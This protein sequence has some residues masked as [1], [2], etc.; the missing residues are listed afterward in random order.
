MIILQFLQ[1]YTKSTPLCNFSFLWRKGAPYA[2]LPTFVCLIARTLCLP[3]TQLVV[4][5]GTR[6]PFD[7]M[8]C[9]NIVQLVC[10]SCHLVQ[11]LQ[12]VIASF[13]QLKHLFN[14]L[15]N[16]WVQRAHLCFSPPRCSPLPV[17]RPTWPFKLS[18]HCV[19]PGA[20]T[21]TC[22]LLFHQARSLWPAQIVI[23]EACSPWPANHLLAKHIHRDGPNPQPDE[24]VHHDPQTLWPVDAH[25]QTFPLMLSFK[26]AHWPTISTQHS[27]VRPPD[28]PVTSTFS[29]THHPS[30]LLSIFLCR[31]ACLYVVTHRTL[32]PVL[33]CFDLRSTCTF[34]KLLD[35]SLAHPWTLLWS[36]HFPWMICW[37]NKCPPTC[38]RYLYTVSSLWGCQPM[39]QPTHHLLFWLFLTS[40]M[41][42]V[43]TPRIAHHISLPTKFLNT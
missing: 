22:P 34:T 24:C 21:T 39:V 18:R 19:P 7:R 30:L 17:F 32:R 9:Q 3:V 37:M 26:L 5:P 16:H 23:H 35:S 14:Q 20:F 6:P 1:F 27:Y 41:V 15:A 2:T 28:W 13:H 40:A 36:S 43:P 31:M 42:M 4:S 29:P 8:T 25:T 10:L 33:G 11:L 12:L 38:P